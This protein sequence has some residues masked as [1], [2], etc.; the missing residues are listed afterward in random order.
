MTQKFTWVALTIAASILIFMGVGPARADQVIGRAPAAEL[1]IEA[2][3][4]GREDNARDAVREGRV[5]SPGQAKQAALSRYPGHYL[6]MSLAGQTYYVKIRTPDNRVV[7][8]S[9]DATSGRV[10]GA[11]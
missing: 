10:M 8:V 9:V 2:Q 1:L 6:D 3:Y 7:V 4:W 11:R 5:I